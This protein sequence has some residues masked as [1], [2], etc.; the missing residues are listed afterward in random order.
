MRIFFDVDNTLLCST[1]DQWILR[2]GTREI[3]ETLKALGQE[4]YI[5][6]ATGQAHCERLVQ[7]YDLHPYIINCF[8][9]DPACPVKPDLIIDDDWFLVEK[10]SGFV[11]EAFRAPNPNDR[12]L[13]R[14]LE[15]LKSRLEA[16]KSAD[17]Q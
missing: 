15:E 16:N 13:F 14:V 12:E 8:D 3:M 6:S 2:P 5:W 10:Y 4:L 1:E 17:R 9:K 7:R 11:V